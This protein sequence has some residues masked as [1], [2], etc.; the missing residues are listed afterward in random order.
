MKILFQWRTRG[1]LAHQRQ[2]QDVLTFPLERNHE[3]SADED[4]DQCLLFSDCLALEEPEPCRDCCRALKAELPICEYCWQ[5]Q[6]LFTERTILR[7][8]LM[9]RMASAWERTRSSN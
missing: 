5:D 3:H 1:E 7:C 2:E 6:A 8:F 9:C 4:C